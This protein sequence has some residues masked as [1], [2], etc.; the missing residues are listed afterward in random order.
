MTLTF[1]KT[2]TLQPFHP[3]HQGL[4]LRYVRMGTI[5]TRNDFRSKVGLSTFASQ[6]REKRSP[7]YRTAGRLVFAPPWASTRRI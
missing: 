7:S 3:A 4:S 5:P 6:E 1:R 2:P